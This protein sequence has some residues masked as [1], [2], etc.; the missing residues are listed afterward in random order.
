MAQNLNPKS[1]KVAKIFAQIVESC[2]EASQHSVRQ[3]PMFSQLYMPSPY[4]VSGTPPP[5]PFSS[6]PFLPQPKIPQAQ[7]SVRHL[8]PSAQW[9]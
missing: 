3:D 8:P 2:R 6:H 7:G 4:A 5:L 9:R 1:E